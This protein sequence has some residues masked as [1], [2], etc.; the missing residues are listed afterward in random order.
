MI[1]RSLKSHHTKGKFTVNE[2]FENKSEN[3]IENL[4]TGSVHEYAENLSDFYERQARR[5]N[6]TIEEEN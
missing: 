4:N 6:K 2:N 3:G 5:Y 1:H